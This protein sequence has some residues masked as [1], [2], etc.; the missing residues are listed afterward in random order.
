MR[1]IFGGKIIK[2]EL[3]D[4][5]GKNIF[6]A[7]KNFVLPKNMDDD[8]SIV[9]FKGKNLPDLER[10][11]IV[12]IV[13]TSKANDRIRY[14]GAVSM[15]MDTQLNVKILKNN[16]TQVLQ[17]R[18]RFFKIKINE[19]GRA[20]FY[21]RGEQ[22]VR[23][24]EP[25]EISVLDINV[26]GIFFSSV[27]EFMEGDIVCVDIDLFIDNP[28]NTAVKILRVQRNEDGTIKGYGCLFESLT[29]AQEDMIGRFIMKVQSE[30]RRKEAAKDDI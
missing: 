17:E 9:I 25:P 10:N 18:R 22:T 13:T 21:V 8:D 29:G 15:S 27:E 23:Y 4:E 28:L 14:T 12:S 20:L 26:G 6:T 3:L 2:V 5:K 11:T 1:L 16:E 30:Q 7:E 19:K 24:D